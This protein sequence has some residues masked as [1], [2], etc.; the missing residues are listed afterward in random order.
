MLHR[1]TR[2]TSLRVAFVIAFSTP[3]LVLAGSTRLVSESF[4]GTMATNPSWGGDVSKNGRYTVFT[5]PG[6]EFDGG[7]ANGFDQV[8][9]R[10]MKASL[11]RF[12]SV[13]PFDSGPAN[14]GCSNPSC[15]NDGKVIA[16][17]SGATNLSSGDLNQAVD[18]FVRDLDMNTTTKVSG[19]PGG[20]D[21]DGAAWDCAISGNGRF[22]LF[23]SAATNV[24]VGD[25]NGKVDVFLRDLTTGV[26]SRMSVDAAGVESN[27][28]SYGAEI[29]SDGRYVTF[30]SDATNLVAADTNGLVDVFVKD[31]ITG[32]VDR[33]S[34]SSIGVQSDDI[35]LQPSLSANGRF[36]AFRSYATNLVPNDTN[37][38]ADVFVHDRKHHTTVRASL[39]PQGVEA[40]A[41]CDLPRISGNARYV[42]F[43]TPAT[44]F[45]AQATGNQTY[46]RDLKKGTTSLVSIDD[47]KTPGDGDSFPN[48]I[49]NNGRFVLFSSFATNLAAGDANGVSDTFLRDR[50]GKH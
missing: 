7:A 45:S 42:V 44:N 20:G 36:V 11:T 19:N 49:S 21:A 23:S 15:S 39:G 32:A 2:T 41:Y 34:I 31:R 25:T 26:T 46:V 33:V 9:V 48:A 37:A 38:V 18:V 24:I 14:A 8:F 5:S 29:S 3:H 17:L 30:V 1:L 16:F 43:Q 28:H 13:S 40:N 35:S 27:G 22:V 12:V 4:S 6:A 50:T 47:S 10:D